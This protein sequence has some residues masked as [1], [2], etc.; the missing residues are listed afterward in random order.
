MVTAVTV[1]SLQGA[2]SNRMHH[3]SSMP[4]PCGVPQMLQARCKG[5]VCS[6]TTAG[7]EVVYYRNKQDAKPEE[8]QIYSRVDRCVLQDAKPEVQQAYSRVG[9]V[10]A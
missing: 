5:R 9:S 8:E 2:D 6:R 1:H 7:S 4:V 3:M 10:D